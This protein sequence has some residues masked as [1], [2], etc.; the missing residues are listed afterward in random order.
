MPCDPIR[1]IPSNPVLELS[2]LQRAR[3]VRSSGI[4]QS[5]RRLRVRQGL[6][7]LH[8]IVLRTALG[9]NQVVGARHHLGLEGHSSE[10]RKSLSYFRLDVALETV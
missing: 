4:T 7:N 6:E 1:P 5:G 2:Q 3:C 8:V 10:L 9:L